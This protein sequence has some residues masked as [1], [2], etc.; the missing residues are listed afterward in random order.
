METTQVTD[1][2]WMFRFPVGQA[3]ALRLPD[4]WALVDTGLPG[5]D[6]QILDALRDLGAAPG[7]LR[8]ILLTHSH[9]DHTGSAAPLA[10][11]TGAR[12]LAGTA[13]ADVIRGTAPEPPPALLDWEIPIHAAVHEQISDIPPAPPCPV[14]R[15]LADGDTLDWGERARVLHVPGHTA[16]GIALHLPDSGVLFTGDTIANVPHVML[17][18]FNTDRPQAVASFHRQAALDVE[19]ACF[20]HGEPL[21]TGAGD[22]LRAAGKELR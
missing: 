9:L 13:D 19:T 15:E 20:G 18:V 4:G 7:D 11:A 21:L 22:A 10:A 3:Y 8:E 5:Y 1:N 14:D 12:V 17:G 2:I 16:G 6:R